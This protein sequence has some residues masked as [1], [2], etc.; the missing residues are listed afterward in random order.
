[1]SD[2]YS[3]CQFKNFIDSIT[4]DLYFNLLEDFKEE[5]YSMEFRKKDSSLPSVDE[6]GQFRYDIPIIESEQV[7]KLKIS[8]FE[9]EDFFKRYNFLENSLI[10]EMDLILNTQFTIDD[11]GS[12]RDDIINWLKERISGISF[13][14]NRSIF[15]CDFIHYGEN[16]CKISFHGK[17]NYEIQEFIKELKWKLMRTYGNLAE[18]NP[19]YPMKINI[20][21]NKEKVDLLEL[22]QL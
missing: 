19:I 20:K 9:F 22:R 7:W 14:S 3:F 1:M 21:W 16:Y 4:L 12:F 8:G 13:N 10:E 15:E 6:Y 17:F 11:S 5:Y 2:V 18:K